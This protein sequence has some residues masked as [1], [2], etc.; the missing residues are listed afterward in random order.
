MEKFLENYIVVSVMSLITIYSLF[1]DDVR[2]L[3]VTVNEDHIF[4]IITCVCFAAFAIEIFL[5][6]ISKDDY[7]L[8][9][10]F[11][12]D[13]VSTISMLPDIGWVW[14]AMTGGG[15]AG[16]AGNAA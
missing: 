15:G 16:E 2:V 3:A 9:F 4:Y 5:A 8:G 12:L 10:F 7:F 13:I 1:F 11:W 14:D 6:S